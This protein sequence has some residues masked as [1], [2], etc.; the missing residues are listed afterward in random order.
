PVPE[1]TPV[2]WAPGGPGRAGVGWLVVYLLAYLPTMFGIRWM[3][4]VG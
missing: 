1:Q 2:F 3:L 4:K